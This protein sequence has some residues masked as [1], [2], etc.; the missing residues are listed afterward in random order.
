MKYKQFNKLTK[1]Q[2][3]EWLF[4]E[5]HNKVYSGTG[6]IDILLVL[7]VFKTYL[8]VL[9]IGTIMLYNT[10]KVQEWTYTSFYL[11]F[12]ASIVFLVMVCFIGLEIFNAIYRDYKE[13]KLLKKIKE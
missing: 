12:G 2:K 7:I 8:F 11:L 10:G 6:L 5:F 13:R 4:N 9:M 3:E 1:K